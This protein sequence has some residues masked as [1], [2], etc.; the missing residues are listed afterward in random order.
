VTSGPTNRPRTFAVIAYHPGTDDGAG[1]AKDSSGS[2]EGV[3]RAIASRA[4][5]P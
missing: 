3:E 5:W 4:T 2:L 1:I